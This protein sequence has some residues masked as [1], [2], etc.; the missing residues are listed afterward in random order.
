MITGYLLGALRGVTIDFGSLAMVGVL[1]VVHGGTALSALGGPLEVL[2]VNAL[3]TALEYAAPGAGVGLTAPANPGDDGKVPIASAGDLS[4]LA[5]TAPD[6]L[7]VWDGTTWAAGRTILSSA[8]AVSG[9]LGVANGGLGVAMGAANTVPRVNAAGLAIEY[10]KLTTDNISATAAILGTQLSAS[11]AIAASQLADG[12]ANTVLAG[13]TPNTWTATPRLTRLACGVA[14]DA[15]V[16]GLFQGTTADGTT[17]SLRAQNNAGKVGLSVN[18]LGGVTFAGSATIDG[19]LYAAHSDGDGTYVG[20]SVGNLYISTSA[21]GSDLFLDAPTAG[22]TVNVRLGAGYTIA[23]SL[24]AVAGD[25]IAFGADPADAGAIR[26]SHAMGVYG[27]LN[28]AGADR[29]GVTWGVVANDT[30]AF[31]DVAAATRVLGS[32]IYAGDGT[33]IGDGTF[34]IRLSASGG[35]TEIASKS[36]LLL[37]AAAGGSS[38]LRCGAAGSVNLDALYTGAPIQVRVGAGA[39]VVASANLVA[40]ARGVFAIGGAVSATEMP[41]GTGSGVAFMFNA[42]VLPTTGTPVGGVE[43]W[44]EAGALKAK[45]SSSTVTTIAAAEPHCPRCGNDYIFEARNDLRGHHVAI[46][47]TCFLDEAHA[48]GLDRSRFAFIDKLGEAA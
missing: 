10:A 46:C 35:G 16:A 28:A 44:A 22:G 34:G 20:N 31:G 14:V 29:A 39:Q 24:G 6:N 42:T 47:W 17:A 36:H 37:Q 15:N 11:A 19:A 2:R 45:G 18:G 32:S 40:T 23:M 25:Y 5:G 1:P 21:V 9:I 3:G 8:A 48:H 26:L 30:W 27:E 38:Y 12:G 43:F 41:A 4:Y 13:G 7:L 33:S